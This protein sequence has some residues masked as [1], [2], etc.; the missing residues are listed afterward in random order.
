MSFNF[1][2]LFTFAFGDKFLEEAVAT[3]ATSTE[4]CCHS[5]L[6]CCPSKFYAMIS[7]HHCRAMSVT[8][9]IYY[10]AYDVR[11]WWSYNMKAEVKSI[12]RFMLVP[13]SG[14]PARFAQNGE[15][16]ACVSL[17]KQVCE[18]T[19]EGRL[20]LFNVNTVI[21][22]PVSSDINK[23]SGVVRFSVSFLFLIFASSKIVWVCFV[24]YHLSDLV[25]FLC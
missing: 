19:S 17:D 9:E 21:L 16:F 3:T 10:W 11:L 12:E 1:N 5:T 7:S 13:G 24:G 20:V 25:H 6:W 22:L 2:D 14:Q 23:Q 18:D 8:V 4:I 15:L